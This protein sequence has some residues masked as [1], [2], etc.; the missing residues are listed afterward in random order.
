VANKKRK[1]RQDPPSQLLQMSALK[2]VSGVKKL[3]TL[4]KMPRA[5]L[6][7]VVILLGF[8]PTAGLGVG[9]YA[10]GPVVMMARFFAW[11]WRTKIAILEQ[12]SV[13]GFTNRAL[14][15][16]AHEVLVAFPGVELE[17]PGKK[18]RV[19]GN[20][21]RKEFVQLSS[22]A[23]V[24][25]QVFVFGGSQGAM[26]I[27]TLVLQALPFL[28]DAGI[29]WVHQTGE[30][31]FERVRAGHE[32]AGS[33]AR[34]EKFIYEMLKTYQDSSLII[35]RAGSSTLSELALVGRASI[36]IPF[37]QASDNHQEK[38]ARIFENQGATEVIL[39]DAGS[40]KDLA[41]RILFLKSHPER[42]RAM[43]LNILKLGRGD[44]AKNIAAA[45]VGA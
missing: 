18:T 2:G 35:C 36:L 1:I 15:I 27:N 28:E 43:E 11:M 5:L 14:S 39:Q 7:C 37:P 21:V 13:P 32:T 3:G 4:L 10:S 16:F 23:A 34:V 45:L 17:F 29:Q 40:G 41:E 20:P 38:N 44:A 42:L 33:G 25:F 26:G 22:P 6:S 30:R 19:T 24:P 31:E 12:N 9:G 8:R